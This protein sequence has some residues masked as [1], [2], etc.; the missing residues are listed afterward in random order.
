MLLEMLEE[1]LKERDV[2]S[3]LRRMNFES[4]GFQL[5]SSIN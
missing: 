4:E 3:Y 2:R 5:F 1:V